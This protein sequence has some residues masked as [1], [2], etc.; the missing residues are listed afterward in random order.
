MLVLVNDG[1][2][3]MPALNVKQLGNADVF[4]FADVCCGYVAE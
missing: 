4:T 1:S 2:E 3:K